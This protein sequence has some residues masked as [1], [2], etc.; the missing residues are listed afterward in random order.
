[1][2]HIPHPLQQYRWPHWLEQ[3]ILQIHGQRLAGK[4]KFVIGGEDDDLAVQPV[5]AYKFRHFK[6]GAA[7]QHDI[8][9][10]QIRDT[11]G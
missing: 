6:A 11:A 4:V 2:Q 1:M 9:Q 8:Q 10:D 5:T 3:V 7:P